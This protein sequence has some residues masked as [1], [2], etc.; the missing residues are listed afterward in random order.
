LNCFKHDANIKL[1]NNN[2]AE[3]TIVFFCIRELISSQAPPSGF[4]GN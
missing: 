3:R 1:Y 4:F 2:K